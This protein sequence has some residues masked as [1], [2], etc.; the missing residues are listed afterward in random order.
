[1]K[2]EY[3]DSIRNESEKRNFGFLDK[4][5]RAVFGEIS[6]DGKNVKLF[7]GE[8]ESYDF[9][10]S[11][12]TGEN[13]STVLARFE[14]TDETEFWVNDAYVVHPMG[15]TNHSIKIPPNLDIRSKFLDICLNEP[16]TLSHVA[17][18]FSENEEQ[19][20]NIYFS[21][22]HLIY[23]TP[24]NCGHEDNLIRAIN[25]HAKAALPLVGKSIVQNVIHTFMEGALFD[26]T[27][28]DPEMIL[29]ALFKHIG[30]QTFQPAP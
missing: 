27:W 2:S 25:N 1:M 21:S 6:P 26:G 11:R 20:I 15:I 14:H 7:I 29:P 3:F 23:M 28:S 19:H 12:T 30:I 10:I 8:N 16:A 18:T 4:S 5:R 13:E 9:T 24:A 17:M 22:S